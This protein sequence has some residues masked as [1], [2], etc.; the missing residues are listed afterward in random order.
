MVQKKAPS[1][2]KST[3]KSTKKKVSVLTKDIRT[4]KKSESDNN[5]VWG[6]IFAVLTAV[7]VITALISLNKGI[8]SDDGVVAV[9]NGQEITAGEITQQYNQLPADVR[10][11][12][13]EEMVLNQTIDKILVLEYAKE[14]GITVSDEEVDAR[15]DELVSAFGVDLSQ[16]EQL[17]ESQN[18]TLED[19]KDA[20]RE[21][22]LLT[23][24]VDEVIMPQIEILEEQID[25]YYQSNKDKYVASEGQVHIRHILVEN[26][27]TAWEL[28][29]MLDNGADFA[30]LAQTYSTGPSAPRGGDLGFISNDSALVE[31]FKVVALSLEEGEVSDPV[32]TQ[33]GWHVIKR[34]PD[35]TPVSEVR[36]DIVV[37]LKQQD[38][39]RVFQELLSQ[40]R[41]EADIVRY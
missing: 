40:L 16:L 24:L 9:V 38:A 28:V 37:I 10:L 34:D 13:S 5:M 8:S 1:K 14:Q 20:V 33:F 32:K 39:A 18:L 30:E 3:R 2:T 19:Y 7:L 6:V 21:E 31:E 35:I 36:E 23:K 4:G 22:V 15:L 11:Q 25:E 12:V 17:L 27:T 29:E 41:S 26:E